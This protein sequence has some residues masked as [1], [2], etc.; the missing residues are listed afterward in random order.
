MLLFCFKKGDAQLLSA[1]VKDYYEIISDDFKAS[2]DN[3]LAEVREQSGVK[4]K[5]S[6]SD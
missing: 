4:G 2:F 6:L 5:T 1:F 3:Y